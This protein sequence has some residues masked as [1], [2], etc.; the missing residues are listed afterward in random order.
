MYNWRESVWRAVPFYRSGGY[1]VERPL[2][3]REVPGSIPSADR[4]P[5][6]FSKGVEEYTYLAL[7]C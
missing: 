4:E 5:T 3:M 6:G 7:G 2:P 1:M